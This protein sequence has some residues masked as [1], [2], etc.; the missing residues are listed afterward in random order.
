MEL[1]FEPGPSRTPALALNY[2]T[3]LFPQSSSQTAYG[4]H[5]DGQL[6]CGEP[7]MPARVRTFSLQPVIHH[8]AKEL[9]QPAEILS[10]WKWWCRASIHLFIEWIVFWV[11]L[12]WANHWLEHRRKWVKVPESR[13]CAFQEGS[14]TRYYSS[15]QCHLQNLIRWVLSIL[16]LF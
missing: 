7:W 14:F 6:E 8:M 13:Q 12:Q 3:V 4:S 1:G 15:T 16:A 9:S 2:Y 11:Y 5:R 10:E